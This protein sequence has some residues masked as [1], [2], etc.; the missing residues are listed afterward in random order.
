MIALDLVF[1]D[2][3]PAA[4]GGLEQNESVENERKIDC[5]A[6]VNRG[7]LGRA[8]NRRIMGM[9][10]FGVWLAALAQVSC[11][12]TTT[13]V[14]PTGQ[15]RCDCWAAS[16]GKPACNSNNL[17]CIS[18]RCVNPTASGY[19]IEHT[20]EDA[21]SGD[22]PIS[23]AEASPVGSSEASPIPDSAPSSDAT[24]NDEPTSVATSD[25]SGS[26]DDA[27][28]P[29]DSGVQPAGNLATNGD[30][31]QGMDNW[32]VQ[33]GS[34]K[35][36]YPSATTPYLCVTLSNN[37]SYIIG[38]TPSSPLD[39]AAGAT[40]T[41]SY[42]AWSSGAAV[43]V[44][45]KVGLSYSP[46]TADLDVNSPQDSATQTSICKAPEFKHTFTTKGDDPSA[47]IAFLVVGSSATAGVDVCFDNVTLVSSSP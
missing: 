10:S 28:D 32:A 39:L 34:N 19:E 9:L 42:R 26:S 7:R 1:F 25:D 15:E 30:F 33:G 47:G 20:S 17:V 13:I 6:A 11:T 21:S 40:Y 2:D 5:G 45:A 14:C 43:S 8:M 16:S 24:S 35:S 27:C 12:S 3:R 37:V 29:A 46:Y 31:S 23:V 22:G 4:A 18:N 36:G 41:L 44:E 38:W